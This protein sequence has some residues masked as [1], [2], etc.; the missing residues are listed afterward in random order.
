MDFK[1]SDG[2][3]QWSRSG[4]SSHHFIPIT[5]LTIINVDIIRQ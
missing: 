2:L 1:F 4:P 3:F 5:T